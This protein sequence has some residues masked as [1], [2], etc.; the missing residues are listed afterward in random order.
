MRGMSAA[1]LVAAFLTPGLAR[2]AR[3]QVAAE[4]IPSAGASAAAGVAYPYYGD[5]RAAYPVVYRSASNNMARGAYPPGL[6]VSPTHYYRG[7]AHAIDYYPPWAVGPPP[8]ISRFCGIACFPWR[9]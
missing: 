4:P 5:D 7:P 9:W 1:V 8:I 3:A 2:S 6:C